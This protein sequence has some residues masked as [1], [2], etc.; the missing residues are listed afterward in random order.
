MYLLSHGGQKPL[1]YGGKLASCKLGPPKLLTGV[2]AYELA[3]YQCVRSLMV[4]TSLWRA[5]AVISEAP[6]RPTQFL[7]NLIYFASA[8]AKLLSK[9]VLT[10]E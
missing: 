8:R 6:C 4:H 7:L 9:G 5:A 10:I 3:N 2:T 1:R